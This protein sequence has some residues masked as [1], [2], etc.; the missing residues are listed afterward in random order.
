MFEK[1]LQIETLSLVLAG[2]FNPVI[3]QPFWLA[4]KNLI[5]ETEAENADVEV[6]HNDLVKYSLNDWAGIEI[7]KNRCEFKSTKEP[8]FEILKDL[9]TSSF[10]VLNETPIR[11]L[12]MNHIFDLKLPNED[13]YLKFGHSLS[14]L[15]FWEDSIKDP[16]LLNIEI[17]EVDRYD[18]EIGQR[19]VR[20][21]P[22][23]QQQIKYGVTVNINNHFDLNKP[24][25]K[26]NAVDQLEKKWKDS[27]EQSRLILNSI[28][29]KM[30]F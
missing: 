22:T 17:I 1:Y 28:F 2:D 24:E 18:E 26:I 16:K 14:N 12:G 19:R 3:L 23:D 30:E 7:T 5:R 9:I 25:K 11:A 13:A 21:S 15:N 4:N 8:Y 29:S 6:I 27:F 10:R 20:I